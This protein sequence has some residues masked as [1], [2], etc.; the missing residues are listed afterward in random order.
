[1]KKAL[2]PI[3]PATFWAPLAA[4]FLAV[5]LIIGVIVWAMIAL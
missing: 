2:A 3:E 5:A 1:M 4:T